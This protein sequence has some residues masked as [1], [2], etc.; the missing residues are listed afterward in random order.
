MLAH[1]AQD[2]GID[3]IAVYALDEPDALRPAEA[4]AE[5]GVLAAVPVVFGTSGPAEAIAASDASL[6]EARRGN[7]R[8]AQAR[9]ARAARALAADAQASWR[10]SEGVPQNEQLSGPPVTQ[11]L[12]EHQAKELFETLG[13]RATA[14]RLCRDRAEAL[15]AFS[16]LGPPA[17]AKIV[18]P[19]VRHKSDVGG[20]RPNLRT[21]DQLTAALNAIDAIEVSGPVS[22]LIEAQA[23]AGPELLVGGVRDPSFGPVV[24]LSL[25]GVDVELAR[26]RGAAARAALAGRSRRHG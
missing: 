21:R 10:L 23:S 1:V 25:G 2:P 8:R 24:A 7:V 13:V 20:V 4:V 11:T 16:E 15:R 3:V 19:Q 6:A 14:R 22:Y 17:V 9:A 5:S 26:Q 12:D 18:S